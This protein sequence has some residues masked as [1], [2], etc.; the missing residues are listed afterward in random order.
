MRMRR[1]NKKGDEHLFWIV[2]IIVLVGIFIIV[3]LAGGI[4]K[5]VEGLKGQASLS[6]CT[7]GAIKGTCSDVAKDDGTIVCLPALSCEK[8]KGVQAFCCYNE[9]K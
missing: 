2:G 8:T 1:I 4:P 6:D 9:Q 3:M 7:V 5:I